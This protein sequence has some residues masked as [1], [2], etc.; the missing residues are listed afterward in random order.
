MLKRKEVM[1]KAYRAKTRINAACRGA[2]G[3]VTETPPHAPAEN[4][5]QLYS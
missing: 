2:S 3:G 4:L 5:M 1:M